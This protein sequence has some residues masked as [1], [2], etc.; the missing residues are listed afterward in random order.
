MRTNGYLWKQK[1]R[2]VAE[3]HQNGYRAT[4][5]DAN[6]QCPHKSPPQQHHQQVEQHRPV[7]KAA[8]LVTH[9]AVRTPSPKPALK[10]A[11]TI[12]GKPFEDVKLYYTLRKEL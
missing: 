4:N 3:P 2:K 5:D 10:A 8:Q 12:L 6:H 7:T 9:W 1:R 11:D